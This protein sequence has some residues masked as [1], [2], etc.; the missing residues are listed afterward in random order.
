MSSPEIAAGNSTR[1]FSGVNLEFGG[2]DAAENADHRAA[3]QPRFALEAAYAAGEIGRAKASE[4][5]RKLPA[6]YG[7]GLADAPDEDRVPES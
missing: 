1:V 7:D 6:K 5:G 2:A 3:L 4:I